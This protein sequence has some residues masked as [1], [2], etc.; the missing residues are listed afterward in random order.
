[1]K[2]L[3]RPRCDLED[4]M[5]QYSK[6]TQV[7]LNGLAALDRMTGAPSVM[8]PTHLRRCKSS[9]AS[10]ALLGKTPCDAEGAPDVEPLVLSQRG[11]AT[12]RD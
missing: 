10:R 12:Q 5:Y 3:H 1:M 11:K 8:E 6:M 7:T 2:I 9:R 4:P